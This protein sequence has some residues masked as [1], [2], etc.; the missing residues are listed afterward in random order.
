M[1]GSASAT[2]L[3]K[4]AGRQAIFISSIWLAYFVGALAGTR[5]EAT[6]GL[7]ALF[8]PAVLLAA[9][10]AVDQVSPLS[11][12]EEREQMEAGG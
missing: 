9:A 10:V 6:F 11:L 3:Q 4:Q 8:A 5:T 12:R 2:D 7:R 1:R